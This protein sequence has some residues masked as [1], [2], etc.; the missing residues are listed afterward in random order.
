VRPDF[1]A[2]AQAGLDLLLAQMTDEE[3]VPGRIVIAPTLITRDSV[4]PPA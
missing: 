4:G 2:V 3:P 1:D